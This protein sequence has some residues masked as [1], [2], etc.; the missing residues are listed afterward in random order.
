MFEGDDLKEKQT[1]AAEKQLFG[2]GDGNSVA[3][4]MADKATEGAHTE[5]H[6]VKS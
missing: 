2:A 3:E 5:T 1:M 6:E 4:Q